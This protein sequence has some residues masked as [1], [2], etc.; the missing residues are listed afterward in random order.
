MPRESRS[1][2]F[3]PRASDS[4]P[5]VPRAAPRASRDRVFAAAAAEFARRGYAGANV[6]RIARAARLN[7]AMIYYHFKSKAALYREILR[8]MFGSVGAAVA[9]VEASAATPQEKIRRF[10]EAI[11]T[12]AEARP[13]FPPIWLREIAE[14]GEHV[15]AATL[16]YLR[17]VLGALGR[18]LDEGRRAKAFVAANPLVVQAGIIAPLMFFL[19]TARLR[20]KM[21]RSGAVPHAAISR[22]LVVAHIQR[23]TLAQLEGKIT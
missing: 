12:A 2:R 18:I 6:D 16:R 3:G 1:S 5:R 8:D 21:Q 10:I 19:A 22:D 17:D 23:I 15:D 4:P 13:H 11:A 9:E 14:G 7:K 20:R